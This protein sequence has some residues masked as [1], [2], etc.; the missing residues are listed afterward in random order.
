MDRTSMP[1]TPRVVHAL[2]GRRGILGLFL[3]ALLLRTVFALFHA[4][5]GWHLH[6]D[7]G[8]YLTLAM[9][10]QH[11]VYSLFHPLDVPDTTRMPGYPFLIHLLGGHLGLVL[12]VQ[13][14]LSAAKVPLVHALALRAGLHTRWALFAAGWVAI[15]PT[16]II[17]SGSILTEAV[18]ITAVLCGTLLLV[19]GREPQHMVLAALCFALAT[20]FRPNAL[21]IGLAAGAAHAFLHHRASRGHVLFAITLVLSVLPWMMRNQARTGRFVLSDSGPVAAAYFHLPEVLTRAQDQRAS[22]YLQELHGR[23]MA[24]DWEDRAQVAAYFN[25]LRQDVRNTLLEHPIAWSTAQLRK[26]LGTLAAPGRG[27]IR[28]YFG[29]RSALGMGMVGLALLLTGTLLLGLLLVPARFKHLN[30]ELLLLL[31]ISAAIL[32]SAGISSMDARFK[33][34]ALPLL[35]VVATWAFNALLPALNKRSGSF[36]K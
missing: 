9:N 17:L 18:F 26:T 36:G 33:A 8:Y 29:K 13:V 24:T 30:N 23:S 14:L 32:F 5:Q 7:P 4:T 2:D 21:A 10:L 31:V 3:L 6:F 12:C 28:Q 27:H 25:T 19:K 35:V 22:G 20:W 1:R 15:D 11:G 34:P 16:D